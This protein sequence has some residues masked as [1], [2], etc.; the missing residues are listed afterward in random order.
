MVMGG[1]C[2]IEN[3]LRIASVSVGFCILCVFCHEKKK[4]KNRRMKGEG[5]RERKLS[6]LP[7]PSSVS[8]ALVPIFAGSKSK[9]CTK[10]QRTRLLRRRR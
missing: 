8:F 6:T 1:L 7:S 4:K 2:F 9:K 3:S 10:S 5:G